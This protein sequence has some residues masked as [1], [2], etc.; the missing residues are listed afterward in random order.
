MEDLL[1]SWLLHTN[2][3]LKLLI[4]DDQPVNIRVLYKLFRHEC[5]IFMATSGAQAVQISRAR[6][7]QRTRLHNTAHRARSRWAYE[8]ARS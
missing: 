5:D 6:R 1:Q 8:A 3:R 4:A 2:R 7:V